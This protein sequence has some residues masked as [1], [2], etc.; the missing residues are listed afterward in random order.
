MKRI[1]SLALLCLSVLFS[2]CDKSLSSGGSIP[3]TLKKGDKIVLS[4]MSPLGFGFFKVTGIGEGQW[5]M[6]ESPIIAESYSQATFQYSVTGPDTAVLTSQN[7]QSRTGR[8]WNIT[9]NMTFETEKTGSYV[10]NDV[11]LGT[12]ASYTTSGTFKIK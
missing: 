8:R 7:Y 9:M 12:T 4:N 6:E 3:Q 11:A 10:L 1:L 2:S 5:A